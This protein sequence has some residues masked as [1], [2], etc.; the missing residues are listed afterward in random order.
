MNPKRRFD[1]NPNSLLW[2][3]LAKWKP[4]F[5]PAAAL[6]LLAGCASSGPSQGA[7]AAPAAPA[8]VAPAPPA[9]QAYL[10]FYREKRFV[11]KALNTSVHVDDVEIAELDGGTYLIVPVPAGEHKLYAD[12]EKDGFTMPVEGGKVYY[13]RMGLVPGLWKGNG[14][15]E[16]VDEPAGV[17]EFGTWKLEPA[18]KVKEPGKILK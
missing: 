17:N 3:T 2:K 10:V 14:K 1:M 13:F 11:G 12:E 18:E 8:R 6:V 4:L 16:K 15:L 7:P 9:D 5:L